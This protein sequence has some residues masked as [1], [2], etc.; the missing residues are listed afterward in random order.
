MHLKNIFAAM[1]FMFASDA[2]MAEM[3]LPAKVILDVDAKE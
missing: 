1:S 3:P 2:A